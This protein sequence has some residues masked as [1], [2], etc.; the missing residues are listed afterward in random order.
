MAFTM[1]HSA[2]RFGVTR[3]A[4]LGIA[5]L[6]IAT[7][8]GAGVGYAASAAATAEPAIKTITPRSE[9]DVTN[10]DVLRQQLRNYYGDPLGS[11]TF[12]PDSNYAKEAS[13]VA[14]AG[15]RWISATHHTKKT[16]AILL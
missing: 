1:T 4:A 8:G 7:L 9:R 14:A 11:G 16:K 3:V 13:S 15:K 12:A 2:R 10:I 5:A 6:A